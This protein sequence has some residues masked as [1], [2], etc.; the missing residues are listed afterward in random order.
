MS[1]IDYYIIG[2]IHGHY[3]KLK[4]LFDV[5]KP[6]IR[7]DD[8]VIFL[9]D[10]IDRGPSSFE[11]VEFLVALS[12]TYRTIFLTGN[13]EDMFIR[14]L[15]KVDYAGNFIRNGGDYTIK[16]YIRNCKSM[17]LPETHI[18]FFNN[19]ELYY[20]GSDF[21]AVHAGLNPGIDRLELQS[22]DDLIWIRGEFYLADK[23]WPK[24]VI[25][26]HTPTPYI[27]NSESV[28]VDEERNIIGIDTCAMLDKYPLTCIR[29]PD[30]RI[31]R[32]YYQ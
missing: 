23:K 17:S 30:R 14:Y 13:H 27:I 9:G 20:E 21:I 11:V 12:G 26:G 18:E 31:F 19:L 16:S 25:F 2:D 7:P 3:G 32:A 5:L 1:H 22:R 10:Y 24:T 4:N 29:W 6:H 28:F 8:L 15:R